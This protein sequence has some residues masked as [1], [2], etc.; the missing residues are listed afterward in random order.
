MKPLGK[1]LKAAFYNRDSAQTALDE[2]LQAYRAT[3]RL[4]QRLAIRDQKWAREQEVN[5]SQKR[6]AIDVA[7]EDRVLLKRYPK[8]RKFHSIYEEEPY[9]V[10]SVEEKW[11][12]VQD[13]FGNE[14]RRH[15]D[16]IK[17]LPWTQRI[18]V[19]TRCGDRGGIFA[20]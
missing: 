15:K 20:G 7:A 9:E 8:R 10:V 13:A 14:K 5:V 11:A 17:R 3:L 12:V 16:D 6:K 1:A 19:F 2:L 4:V 18:G